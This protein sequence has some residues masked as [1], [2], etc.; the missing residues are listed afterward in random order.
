MATNEERRE[1][2]KRLRVIKN[3]TMVKEFFNWQD[4]AAESWDLIRKALNVDMGWPCDDHKEMCNILANL[5]EPEQ[6]SEIKNTCT[7]IAINKD[8]FCCSK[9]EVFIEGM[10]SDRSGHWYPIGMLLSNCPKCGA[11]VVQ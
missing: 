4:Q 10:V 5:I 8:N 2:A 1:L 3:D 7:N 9:C 6:E 11:K